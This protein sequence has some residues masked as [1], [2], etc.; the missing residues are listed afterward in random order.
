MVIQ[1]YYAREQVK[2]G[3]PWIIYQT[4]ESCFM[5]KVKHCRVCAPSS[6]V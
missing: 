5:H 1:R 6:N 4:D 2:L 3:G